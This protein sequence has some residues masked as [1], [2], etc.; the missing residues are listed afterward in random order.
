MGLFGK[1]NKFFYAAYEAPTKEIALQSYF[2]F[3]SGIAEYW[4][5]VFFDSSFQRFKKR[6]TARP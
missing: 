4:M 3:S 6:G 1:A 5:N 2:A